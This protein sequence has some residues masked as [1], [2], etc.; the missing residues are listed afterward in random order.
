MPPD[1]TGFAFPIGS[2][3]AG[4]IA[5]KP[6]LTFTND[7]SETVLRRRLGTGFASP[8]GSYK[9]G[10]IAYKPSLTFT[11]DDCETVL[12]RRLGQ[13]LSSSS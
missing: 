3:K 5:Y 9:V 2:Y 7:D 11:N 10:L 8:I 6:S 12:R 4:L 1:G 13:S